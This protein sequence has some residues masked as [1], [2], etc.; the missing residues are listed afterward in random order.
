MSTRAANPGR[1]YIMS[2]ENWRSM[3]GPV[4]VMVRRGRSLP[5]KLAR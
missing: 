4:E 3:V 1:E 5:H 2:L